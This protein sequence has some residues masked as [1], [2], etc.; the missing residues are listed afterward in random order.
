METF[1]DVKGNPVQ[2]SFLSDFFETVNMSLLFVVFMGNG[3]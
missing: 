1:N 3:Y 2:I